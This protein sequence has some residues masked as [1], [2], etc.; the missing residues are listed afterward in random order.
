MLA[1]FCID[2]ACIGDA[3]FNYRRMMM[4]NRAAKYSMGYTA[5]VRPPS[6][7]APMPSRIIWMSLLTAVGGMIPAAHADFLCN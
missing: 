5:V 1:F 7:G 4:R 3:G 6:R 2:E